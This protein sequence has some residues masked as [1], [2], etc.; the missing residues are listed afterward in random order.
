MVVI[1][2]VDWGADWCHLILRMHHVMALFVMSEG[3]GVVRQMM[4]QELCV[5]PVRLFQ[6]QDG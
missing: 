3:L 6:F 2:S 1:E 4:S 5:M